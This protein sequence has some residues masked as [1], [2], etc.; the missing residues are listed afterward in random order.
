VLSKQVHV[1]AKREA[2]LRL[3]LLPVSRPSATYVLLFV[4]D[5]TGAA[6]E[7]LLL[8]LRFIEREAY[9]EAVKRQKQ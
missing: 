4:L 9:K 7:T 6:E 5:E 8:R 2:P 3:Q 1:E